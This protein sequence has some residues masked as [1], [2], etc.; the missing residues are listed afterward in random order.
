[1]YYS[2]VIKMLK[3]SKK[4]VS[5]AVEEVLLRTNNYMLENGY[6]DS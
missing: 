6:E 4:N 2:A 3:R 1:M 5:G